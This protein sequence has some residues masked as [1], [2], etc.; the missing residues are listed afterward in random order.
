MSRPPISLVVTDLDNT[1]Y[2]WLN[3]F[4]P[5]FYAMVHEAAPLIGV[6]EE[7]LLDDLQA[8][9]WPEITKRS[10]SALRPRVPCFQ[11]DAEAKFEALRRCL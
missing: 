5:A 2:D 7:E 9:I 6:D 1:V 10:C 3:A 8:E 11:S 4:V